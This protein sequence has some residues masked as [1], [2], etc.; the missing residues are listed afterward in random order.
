MSLKI[1]YAKTKLKD[2]QYYRNVYPKTAIFLHHTNGGGVEEAI[3]WWNQTPDRVGT[4]LFVARNGDAKQCFEINQGAYHLGVGGVESNLH[5][6][7]IEL[8]SRGFV[9]PE[10]E[11]DKLKYVNY[12]LWPLKTRKVIIPNDEVIELDKEWRGFKF[13]HKYTDEQVVTTVKLLRYLVDRFKINVQKDL[14]NFWEYNKSVATE[15]K[16]G[17]WAH[18][19]VRTAAEGKWD[20]FP[21]ANLIE[22]IYKEFKTK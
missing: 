18:T 20:I 3:D 1:T 19:T 2:N 12:P 10:G 6:I 9:I 13:W 17:I 14:K 8:I 5:S 22:A 7:G 16:P 21:Q 11:G 15:H 4:A